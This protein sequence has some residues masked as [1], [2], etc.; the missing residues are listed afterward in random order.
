MGPD[1]ATPEQADAKIAQLTAI[2]NELEILIDKTFALRTR[3]VSAKP[4]SESFYQKLND[5]A[6]DLVKAIELV[7]Q[8]IKNLRQLK[9]RAQQ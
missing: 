2:R 5:Q 3:A 8:A 7:D 9:Q 6:V 1:N 4:Y